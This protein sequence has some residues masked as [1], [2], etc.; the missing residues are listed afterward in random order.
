VLAA[1]VP[2]SRKGNVTNPAT[3]A[4]PAA[5]LRKRNIFRASSGFQQKVE[6]NGPRLRKEA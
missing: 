5:I 4:M 6:V 1:S 3:M 2:E